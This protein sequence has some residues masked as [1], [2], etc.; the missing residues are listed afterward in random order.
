MN[1]GLDKQIQKEDLI[2]LKKRTENLII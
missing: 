1:S 2:D